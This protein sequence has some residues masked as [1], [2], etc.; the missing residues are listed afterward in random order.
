MCGNNI[1]IDGV[2]MKKIVVT[3]ASGGIGSAITERLARDGNLILAQFRNGKIEGRETVIPIYGD[4]STV[5]GVEKFYK[6]V[7]AYGKIDCLIN[8]AGVALEKLFSDCSDE[9]ISNLIFTDLTSVMLLTKRFVPDFVSLKSGVILNVSSIWGVRGASMETAYSAAKGG[10]ISF[11]EALSK[12]LGPSGVRVNCI[13]P[14]FIDTK[15]NARYT[16]EERQQFLENV[17]LNR[18]GK[19]EEV[20]ETVAFLISDAASYI[21]GQCISIDGGF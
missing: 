5:D 12:E 7:K 2:D 11:T 13:A 15:M 10:L 3:G 8:C 1:N 6:S 21:T 4:F 9:E 18:V 20:A 16:E 17:S 14:G 19:A